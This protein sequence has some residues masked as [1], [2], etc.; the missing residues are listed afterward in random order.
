MKRIGYLVMESA[1]DFEQ[2]LA[3]KTGCELPS[4]GV[5]GWADKD[6]RAIFKDR[7]EALKA[8]DR[9]EHYRLAF[10]ETMMPEK[11]FCHIIPVGFAGE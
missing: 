4:G 1:E 10:G 11:K 5:L 2:A 8:I 9:T 7:K 6:C 3:L